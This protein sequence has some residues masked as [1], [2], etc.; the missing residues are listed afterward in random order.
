MTS[1]PSGVLTVRSCNS[2]SMDSS[3]L[4]PAAPTP[5]IFCSF[6]VKIGPLSS[7]KSQKKIFFFGAKIKNSSKSIFLKNVLGVKIQSLPI[8]RDEAERTRVG[9]LP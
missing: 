5:K 9:N 6:W 4:A 7:A 3:T 8:D 1:F 2:S